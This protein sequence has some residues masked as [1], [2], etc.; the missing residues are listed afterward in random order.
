MNTTNRLNKAERFGRWLGRGW[1][2]YMHHEHRTSAWLGAHG[3]P[4][5]G[6][7]ALMW[8]AKLLVLGILL[9]VAFWLTLLLLFIVAAAW[10]AR[11]PNSDED[12]QKTEWRMG[13]SGYGLYRGDVRI[14]PGDPDD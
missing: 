13:L 14:D 1:R 3:L 4:P 11:N 7:K 10:A 9:Y 8:V 5:S 12:E 2:G 6:A